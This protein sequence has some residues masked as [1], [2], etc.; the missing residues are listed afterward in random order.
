MKP[1]TVTALALAVVVPS[2]AVGA[3]ATAH[4]QTATTP[5]WGLAITRWHLP[6]AGPNRLELVDKQV[7]V[8]ASAAQYLDNTRVVTYHDVFGNTQITHSSPWTVVDVARVGIPRTAKA[9][10]LS[11]KGIITKGA[12]DGLATVYVMIRPYGSTCCAGPPG[13]R[14]Y[15]VDYQLS[16]GWQVE[17]VLQTVLQHGDD[18]RREWVTVDVPLRAGRFEYAWGYRRVEGDWPKGDGVAFEMFANGY[19]A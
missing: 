2:T 8:A 12:S 17:S 1:L 19:G 6:Q 3:A 4:I 14:N 10:R 7:G 11:L 15:P 9:V 5:R 18:G 13:F 16:H